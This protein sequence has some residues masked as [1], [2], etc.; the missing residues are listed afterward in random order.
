LIAAEIEVAGCYRRGQQVNQIAKKWSCSVV[1][2][3]SL[4]YG[5]FEIC[6]APASGQFFVQQI[7]EICAALREQQAFV[8][9][10][11]GLHVHVDS[12][13]LELRHLANLVRLYAN[14]EDLFFR[15]VPP[16]RRHND[17][18][19]RCGSKLLE[20]FAGVA[21]YTKEAFNLAD[22]LDTAIYGSKERAEKAKQNRRPDVRYD[23]LNLH[24]H[25][26]RGTVELR[27]AAGTTNPDKIINWAQIFALLVDAAYTWSDAT[28]TEYSQNSGVHALLNDIVQSWKLRRWF[29]ER[30][31]KFAHQE[32]TQLVKAQV[33]DEPGEPRTTPD[34]PRPS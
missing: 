9:Q 25:F 3:G 26:Y 19:R 12:R 15:A 27:L 24:S 32:Y 6:T 4:P 31:D 14:L 29:Y 21:L 8:T 20:R 22:A 13:D 11:C 18:C 7:N 10:A 34:G 23:A 17:F 30:I 2:D 33:Y 1:H 16:S 5:G 28:I